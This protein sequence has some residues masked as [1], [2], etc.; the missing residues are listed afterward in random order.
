VRFVLATEISNI[1]KKNGKTRK[2]HN[3]VFVPDL[4]IAQKFNAKL[5][6]MGNIKSD[7]RPILGLDVR[8]LLETLLETSERAFLVPAH[9]WTPW[10]SM[11]GSKSGFDS[12]EECFDDLTS[13]IF[14]VE[15]G[16]SS[17]P[18]MNWRVSSLDGL[19]LVSNSDAHS[20]LNLGREANLFDTE[21]SFSAIKTAL[22]NGDPKQFLGTF[23]FYPEEGKYHIDGHRTCKIS[24][25]PGTTMKH[26]GLC[27]ECGK[28][29]TLGVLYRVEELADRK[30]GQK[31]ARSHPYTSSIQ[32]VDILS[33]VLRVGPA[34]KKVKQTY[35]T[36]LNKLGSE[37]DILHRLDIDAIEQAA[38]PLLGEAIARMRRK[39][40]NIIPGYDGEYGHIRIFKEQERQTLLG[41][42][43]LFAVC[44]PEA[45]LSAP[46]PKSRFD[47][48]S[49]KNKN[50]KNESEPTPTDVF[51]QLN[52][53]QRQAVE[54]PDGC[55]LIVAGPGTG[56]TR[57][58]T[59]RIAHLIMSKGVSPQHILAV[60]FTRKAAQEMQQRLSSILGHAHPMP[61][62]ATFHALCFKILNELHPDGSEAI[63]DDDDRKI[64]IGEA[65]K[66][67]KDHGIT[68]SQNS[69]KLLG[70][71]IEA[72][73]QILN[74]ADLTATDNVT[75]DTRALAE[76]YHCYQ[77]L[78]AIQGLNDYEDLIFKVVQLL[79]TDS[80]VRK[81]Y[82]RR[83]QHI[84]IDEYQDLN[85]GQYRI[86][87]ALAPPKSSN[88]NLCV[89]GDPDQ[90]IYGFRGSDVGYFT[91]FVDDHPET[92][93]VQLTRN[94]RSTATI[95]NA[96]FQVIQDHR[97]YAT[98]NRTYSQIDGGKTIRILELGSAKAEAM[99]IARIIARLVGGTGFHS[100]DTGQ[101]DDANLDSARSYADFAVLVR[102]HH[103]LKIIGDVF[104]QDGIPYQIASRQ[105]SLKSWGLAEL[106]SLLSLMEGF[107]SD[108][109]LNNCLSLFSAGLSKKAADHFKSWCYS[110][111]LSQ[112]QG[113]I[114]AKRFPVPGLSR[115]QQQK[116]IDFGEK[117]A[118]IKKETAGMTVVDKLRYL[119]QMPQFTPLVSTEPQSQEA[120]KNLIRLSENFSDNVV[121]FLT[122]AALYTDTDAYLPVAEKVALMSMHAAKGLEFPV[123]FIAGCEDGLIPLWREVSNQNEPIDV[124]EER[125]LFYVAMT[126]AMERLYLTRAK[127]RSL[128]G[129]R[130]SRSPSPFLA[131]IENRLKK[132]A[133]PQIKSKK[134]HSE[135]QQ[136]HL[137]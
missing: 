92:D 103:Q 90:S 118:G 126:R 128:Y 125:R 4:N 35:Q 3:L 96:S 19:T 51:D 99:A 69:P 94:Y 60:T 18:A 24:F 8:D 83:F 25:W 114:N 81:K 111:K 5:D 7:G 112:Q 14:A 119:S 136:L 121:E 79:E 115:S 59:M 116:L 37:F 52:D 32:L 84:F 27:P 98:E 49:R 23:E 9:I 80:E 58:L 30:E 129:K 75:G 21:L 110:K 95:L 16:L 54:H 133:S 64:L 131:D 101:V 91:R 132:D 55:L 134:R 65:I 89:I 33:E 36:V 137:F 62:V 61:L 34:S 123:V 44:T 104:E 26:E 72:K 78:L 11:L 67:V 1:Y 97:L 135:Q 22:K 102:T 6:K 17:D 76:V 86:V 63:I 108:L 2:N 124:A 130:L 28:P 117:I 109:D 15:T 57:T 106:I 31:P 50:K 87:Q 68:I 39:E 127:K 46:K 20:P 43:S 73:Q 66:R 70:Q 42:Q 85:N 113:L 41:Q 40:I 105:N 53:S 71:I 38:V 13:H 47:N 12:I 100:I 122:H 74:P 82:R 29:L 48:V 10:F 107:G 56:K 77:N 45:P 93:V 120:F 88:R